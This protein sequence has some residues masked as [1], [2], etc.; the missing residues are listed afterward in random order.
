MPFVEAAD[1]LRLAAALAGP[2]AICIPTHDGRRGHPVLFGRA[3]LAALKTL[4]GDTGARGLIAQSG[5][6]HEIAGCSAGVLIDVDDPAG[7]AAAEMHLRARIR[8]LS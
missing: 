5:N 7:F 6:V 3:H 8:P 2:D 4:T 1:Y